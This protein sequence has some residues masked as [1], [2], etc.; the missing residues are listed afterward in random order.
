MFGEGH[1]RF[2]ASVLATMLCVAAGIAGVWVILRWRQKRPSSNQN[3]TSND[4]K[5][6]LAEANHFAFLSNSFR[7]APLYA[8]AEQIFRERG[9]KRDELYAKIG[10][11]RAEA[12]TMSFVKLSDFIGSQLAR[13]MVQ[14]DP[15]LKVEFRVPELQRRL[16]IARRELLAQEVGDVI[17]SEGVRGESLLERAGH[18]FGTVLPDELEEFGNLASE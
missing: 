5:A 2:R 10:R 16:R 4:P 13:P 17:G 6:I 1:Q 9:D 8:K 18:P 12:E 15:E 14:N 7:A 3:F 11:L